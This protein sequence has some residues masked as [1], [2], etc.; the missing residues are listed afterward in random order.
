MS[1]PQ[2]RDACYSYREMADIIWA[3]FDKGRYRATRAQLLA[4]RKV[5]FKGSA[6]ELR[7][8]L[9]RHGGK[10]ADRLVKTA[11][12][13]SEYAE[14]RRYFRMKVNAEMRKCIKGLEAILKNITKV[15][16][17]Q[18]RERAKTNAHH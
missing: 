11:K 7:Q 14:V 15:V 1:K 5:G 2:R 10:K 3:A 8:L 18:R 4:A 12:S 17:R 13:G 9:L 6:K 16:D